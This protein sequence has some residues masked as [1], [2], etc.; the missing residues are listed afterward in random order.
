M[1][2]KFIGKATYEYTPF[3]PNRDTMRSN[4]KILDRIVYCAMAKKLSSRGP[5]RQRQPNQVHAGRRPR[6]IEDAVRI[7]HVPGNLSPARLQLA[8][9]RNPPCVLKGL[10][11]TYGKKDIIG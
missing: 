4:T 5:R 8:H 10:F 11:N 1:G 7:V 2:P 9:C 6:R 3:V